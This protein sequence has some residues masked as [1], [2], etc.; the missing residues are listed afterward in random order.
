MVEKYSALP[1]DRLRV[2]S[3]FED[4]G[5]SRI[6]RGIIF[7]FAAWSGPSVLAFR[8]FTEFLSSFKTDSLELIVLDID[9]LTM[10][11]ATILFSNETSRFGGAGELA[12]IRDGIVVGDCLWFD[13]REQ[14]AQRHTMDLLGD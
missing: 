12:W 4:V 8:K 7:V 9:C 6:S 14:L 11:S 10:E 2:V 3:N 13:E 5:L 1:M